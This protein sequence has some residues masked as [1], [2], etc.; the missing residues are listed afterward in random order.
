MCLT[1]MLSSPVFARVFL[2]SCS[3]L[4]ARLVLLFF[5]ITAWFFLDRD[6]SFKA[7][8]KRIW[9]M[10]RELLFWS[11]LLCVIFVAVSRQVVT[12]GIILKSLFPLLLGLWWYPTSYALFLV[13]L[14]FLNK[15]LHALTGEENKALVLSIIVL[16][17]V[18]GLLPKTHVNDNVTGVFAFCLLYVIIAYYKW[19][20]QVV[21][22]RCLA[23]LM[24]GTGYALMIG[25]WLVFR[26]YMV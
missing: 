6:Q 26:R 25:C 19:H 16:W 22:N 3:L 14:P 7:S 4:V 1:Y 8:L 21:G 2:K 24:I 11:L 20:W 5:T 23:R 10:E 9:L 18:V 17:G 12:V 15:G 13:L